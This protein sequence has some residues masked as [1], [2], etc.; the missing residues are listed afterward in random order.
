V[1]GSLVTVLLQIFSWFWEWNH[2]ENR[3]IFDEVK[4]YMYKQWCH[5]WTTGRNLTWRKTDM[6]F[7]EKKHIK[8]WLKIPTRR[9]KT[10][11][12]NRRNKLRRRRKISKWVKKVRH[13]NV[14]FYMDSKW[15]I[16]GPELRCDKFCHVSDTKRT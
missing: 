1:V 16:W 4:A 7:D 14:G 9:R 13:I 10:W 15:R 12:R 8:K 2:F 6:N 5:F 11:S 3:L